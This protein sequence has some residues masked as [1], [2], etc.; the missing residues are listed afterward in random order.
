M[1]MWFQFKFAYWE[2]KLLHIYWKKSISLLLRGYEMNLLNFLA[3]PLQFNST[4]KKLENKSVSMKCKKH[5][6]CMVTE[7]IF[8]HT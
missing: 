1:N 3:N 6:L 5:L 2:K 4:T 7:D 8:G